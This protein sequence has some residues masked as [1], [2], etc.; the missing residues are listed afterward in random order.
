MKLGIESRKFSYFENNICSLRQRSVTDCNK[1]HIDCVKR[2]KERKLGSRL[3]EI[4]N[5]YLK[6]SGAIISLIS[7]TFIL[8]HD[9]QIIKIIGGIFSITYLLFI[10]Y[11]LIFEKRKWINLR[12]LN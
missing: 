7:L 9:N 4:Q 5:K 11:V 1:L 2:I 6:F 12:L 8:K 10:I 3:Q